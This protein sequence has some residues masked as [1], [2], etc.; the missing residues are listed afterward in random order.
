MSSDNALTIEWAIRHTPQPG[1]SESGDAHVAVAFPHGHLLGVIDGLGH[2]P[3]AHEAAQ[4]AVRSLLESPHEPV[5]TLMQECHRQLLS[6]RGAVISLVSVDTRRR[7][8][9][10]MGVGN[11]AAVMVFPNA[12]K[13]EASREYLLLRG[14]V[15]GYRLPPLRSY[16]QAVKPGD[17]LILATDGIR[18]GFIEDIPTDKCAQD[19]ASYIHTMFNRETDDALVLVARFLDG[20]VSDSG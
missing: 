6:T 5:E 20:V 15:V 14:G 13:P 9:T 7:V 3:K 16:I 18:K 17:I 8:M 4:A 19:I 10:W 2:G 11:V 1:E 12:E